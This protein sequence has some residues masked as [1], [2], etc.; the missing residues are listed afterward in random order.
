M[1]AVVYEK[2]LRK[3]QS[4]GSIIIT[5]DLTTFEIEDLEFP[6]WRSG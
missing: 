3:V 6:S 1:K 2:A 4:F 5:P